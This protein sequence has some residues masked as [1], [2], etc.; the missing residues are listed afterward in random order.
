LSRLRD[1]VENG[2]AVLH[3][4]NDMDFEG[5]LSNRLVRDGTERCLARLSEASVKLG[6]FAEEMFPQHDWLAMRNLG[7]VLRHDYNRVLDSIIWTIRTDRL[8][9]LLGELQAFLAQYPEDQET[10]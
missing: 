10:L 2:Q 7:N 6:P 8:P 1:I 3:Y 4:T 5:Y 9:P